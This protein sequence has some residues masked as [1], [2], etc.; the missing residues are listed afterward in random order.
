M[1]DGRGRPAQKHAEWDLPA[2]MDDEGLLR[3]ANIQSPHRGLGPP[4]GLV[5]PEDD[6][7]FDPTAAS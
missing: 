5:A 6:T 4:T 1:E 3:L 2:P 7:V